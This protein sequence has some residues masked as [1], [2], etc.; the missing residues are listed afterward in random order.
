MIFCNQR[1]KK[2]QGLLNIITDY[3]NVHFDRYFTLIKFTTNRRV[4]YET[5]SDRTEIQL[6]K[7]GFIMGEALQD[8]LDDPI[9]VY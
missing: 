6:M 5:I 1:Y 2:L 4:C 7:K 9:Y 8:L 3:A